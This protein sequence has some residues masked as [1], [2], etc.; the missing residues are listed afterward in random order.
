MAGQ[1]KGNE[2]RK[3]VGGRRMVRGGSKV[4]V[5]ETFNERWAQCEMRRKESER[6][7]EREKSE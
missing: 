3:N 1:R 5:Q 2:R 7:K 4:R 6:R